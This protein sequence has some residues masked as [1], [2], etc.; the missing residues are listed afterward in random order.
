MF[1]LFI[2]GKFEFCFFNYQLYQYFLL[3][4]ELKFC[5][6]SLACIY[7]LN[8]PA[9]RVGHCSPWNVLLF[10]KVKPKPASIQLNRIW[11]EW[12]FKLIAFPIVVE[13]IPRKMTVNSKLEWERHLANGSWHL[14]LIA[15]M[16]VRQKLIV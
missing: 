9:L 12:G 1:Y 5:Q 15:H 13:E 16:M 10:T 8:R 4:S 6:I 3:L 11:F 14:I 7:S 2:R